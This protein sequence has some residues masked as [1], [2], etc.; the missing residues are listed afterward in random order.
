MENQL[1]VAIIPLDIA[2]GDRDE[3]LYNASQIIDRLPK[4]VDVIVLPELFSTGFV[5]DAMQMARLAD[6][7]T[8]P[9]TLDWAAKI[10]KKQNAAVCGSTL[11]CQ[12]GFYMNRGFFIEP[13]AET[14]L[15]DKRHLF[16]LS[17]EADIYTPGMSQ[18]PIVR[19]RGWN[20]AMAICYDLRFP[21]WLRNGDAKYDLLLVPAN[22]PDA[23]AYVWKQL[24]V[25]RAIENQAYIAG[26][27]RS[28]H[29]DYGDYGFDR[30]IDFN[31]QVMVEQAANDQQPVIASL[32]QADLQKQRRAFPVL[33]DADHIALITN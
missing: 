7:P 8:A 11:F 31:G 18:S 33:Q 15:Y 3:N 2:W 27:N 10:A 26:A 1:K 28:G 9:V 13:S 22:W 14:A 16:S 32:S 5:T 20:I 19:F 30:F 21:A 12:D 17:N 4:D 29:D 23:R 6:T 24:L 25:A